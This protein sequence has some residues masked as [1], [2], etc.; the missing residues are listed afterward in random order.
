MKQNKNDSHCRS[1]AL[2]RLTFGKFWFLK[3][4]LIKI[5]FLSKSVFPNTSTQPNNCGYHFPNPF[6][7]SLN[8]LQGA[9][10]RYTKDSIIEFFFKEALAPMPLDKR[11]IIIFHC[12]FSSERGPKMLNFLRNTDRGMHAEHYPVLHYPELYILEGGYKRFYH[13]DT[14]GFK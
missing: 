9:M 11:R 5:K 8:S 4:I 13:S 14:V 10:N 3:L 1:C 12:E 2:R 6:T 7:H